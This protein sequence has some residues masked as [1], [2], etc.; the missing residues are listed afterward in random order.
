M[1]TV[2]ALPAV[3]QAP[4]RRRRLRRPLRG[5]QAAGGR[6]DRL[7]GHREGRRRRRHLARQ[8]LPRRRL[9]R[10][11][12]ALLVLLRAQPRLV[13]VVLP[14]AGDPGL[15][16]ARR[17]ARPARCDRF[18]FSTPRWSRAAW[19]D[20]GPALA[21]VETS[22]RRGSPRPPW[23]SAPAGS[24]SR[25]CPTSRAS[26]TSPGDALPL[27]PLGP[28]RRPRRQAGRG[29]RHRR[30]G[31]PD[32]A[33]AAG[34]GRRTSTSTSA[35]RRTCSRATTGTTAGSR[36]SRC[37]TCRA[38]RRPTGPAIYWGREGYVPGFTL[39]AEAGAGR[40]SGWRCANL[41]KGV[42]R[43]RAAGAGSRR[44]FEIGCKRILISN[45][46]YPALAADNVEVVTDRI[47]RV[48]G[49]ARRHRAT[50]PSARSTCSSSPPASSPPSCRS[51]SAS[52]AARAGRWPSTWRRGRHG[53]V[54]GHH[55]ARA[56]RT[57]SCSSAPTPAWATPAWSSSSSR[58]WT[59][60]ATR[61]APCDAHRYA[62]VEPTPGRA[63]GAWNDDLQRRM[64]R[65]VWST[66]GCSSWYLD[67]HGRNTVLWPRTTVRVPQAAG[68]LRRG[69]VR[70]RRSPDHRAPPP[71]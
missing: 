28:R 47:A 29:H 26:T 45:T 19:D 68:A 25:G 13:D 41:A 52:P 24:P 16:P 27:R 7:P 46:Y 2:S 31:D 35:P 55:R 71:P 51:P 63:R 70:R 20:D 39:A 4:G 48:T 40:R 12:P 49:D 65:T 32:R 53:G 22:A 34:A 42:H 57:C 62:A 10:P 17:R 33:G 15:P 50:A 59:T 61:S 37:A 67:E 6:R 60:S 1:P 9:R 66:G 14:A 38:C 64:G 54:Q 44:T 43:P 69:G 5:D 21:V 8:H 18:R 30:L 58:R 36:S 11:E 56:S 23:S 3:S